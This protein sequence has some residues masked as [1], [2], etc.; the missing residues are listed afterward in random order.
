MWFV[1]LLACPVSGAVRYVGM[2]REP[3]KRYAQHCGPRA[4]MLVRAWV[5]GLG[6]KAPVLHIASEH[7]SRGEALAAEASAISALAAKGERLLNVDK[8]PDSAAIRRG[9]RKRRPLAAAPP[10]SPYLQSVVRRALT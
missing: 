9:W 5:S 3:A 8:H 6:G 10:L 2:G 7:S 1:Y 4:S